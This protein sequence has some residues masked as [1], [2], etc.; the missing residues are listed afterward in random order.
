MRWAFPQSGLSKLEISKSMANIDPVERFSI[1]ETTKRTLESSLLIF[2]TMSH[3]H[4]G[5]ESW[6]RTFNVAFD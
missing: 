4:V 2:K 6:D 5:D 1:P 3:L